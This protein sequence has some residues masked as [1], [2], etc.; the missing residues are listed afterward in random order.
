MTANRAS[1]LL[2]L[3]GGRPLTAGE[4]A[5]R[6]DISPSLASAHLS[7][8]LDGGLVTVQQHDRRRH[9]QIASPHV[10]EVIEAM[11]T[12]APE[13]ATSGLRDSTRGQAIRHA[14]T[15]YD[16]LVG[17]VG[18]AL[19]DALQHQRLMPPHLAGGLG[20]GIAEHLI[21]RQW[22]KHIPGTRALRV[23][24]TGRRGLRDEFALNLAHDS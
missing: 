18:V 4:L 17:T 10:A 9:Y 23:T 22:L 16:H 15:C 24:D 6:A 11:L 20:A 21:Q 3:I 5:A 13:R 19:T 14:R 2:A 7:R 1:L 8:L 12:L